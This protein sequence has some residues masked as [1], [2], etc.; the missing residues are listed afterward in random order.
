MKNSSRSNADLLRLER[1]LAQSTLLLLFL[2]L[3]SGRAGAH[4]Y[5]EVRKKAVEGRRE[6]SLWC[7]AQTQPGIETALFLLVYVTNRQRIA[8]KLGVRKENQYRYL[9]AKLWSFITPKVVGRQMAQE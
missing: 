8:H 1:S 4:L 3:A 2:Q 9:Q 7:W 5:T 6:G